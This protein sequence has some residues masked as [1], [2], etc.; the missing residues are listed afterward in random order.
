MKA[1]TSSLSPSSGNHTANHAKGHV[2]NSKTAVCPGTN[3]QSRRKIPQTP[4]VSF[5]GMPEI[6]PKPLVGVSQTKS[7]LNQLAS[8][9]LPLKFQGL[10]PIS[11][12]SSHENRQSPAAPRIWRAANLPQE[13]PRRATSSFQCGKVQQPATRRPQEAHRNIHKTAP[14]VSSGTC[15][16]CRIFGYGSKLSCL[17]LVNISVKSMSVFQEHRWAFGNAS[18]RDA[19]FGGIDPYLGHTDIQTNPVFA[20]H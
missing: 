12:K 1:H 10:N 19:R 16:T 3:R 2:A 20:C 13:L 8:F 15:Q 18:R 5:K 17:L 11:K 7:P 4:L 14:M 6:I 9:W